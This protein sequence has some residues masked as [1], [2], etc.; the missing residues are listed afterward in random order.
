MCKKGLQKG[1][2]CG[3]VSLSNGK[4]IVGMEGKKEVKRVYKLHMEKLLAE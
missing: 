1:T 4:K 2:M 3:K